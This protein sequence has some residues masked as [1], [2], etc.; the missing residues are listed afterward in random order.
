MPGSL[1]EELARFLLTDM[2]RCIRLSMGIA[3]C[4]TSVFPN[5]GVSSAL[6][7]FL[8]DA[9]SLIFRQIDT[10]HSKRNSIVPESLVSLEVSN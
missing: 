10:V 2:C 9:C 7:S 8:E 4:K 6:L 1:A 3:D 5:K